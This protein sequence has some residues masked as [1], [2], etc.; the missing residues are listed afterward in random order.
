M[1]EQPQLPVLIAGAGPC[2]LVAALTLKQQ[3]IP[4]IVIERASRSK[5]CANVGSGYD[6]APTALDILSNRL[7]LEKMTEIYSNF[8]GLRIQDMF[9][10]D[11]R[12]FPMTEMAKSVKF[13]NDDN[14]AVEQ[15]FGTVN[16]AD[17]QSMLLEKLFSSPESEEGVLRCG[18]GIQSYT[19]KQGIETNGATNMV[20]V[21]LSDG[22]T[23]DG[24]ALLA[25]DGI[26]S[27]IRKQL[28]QDRK[29]E[30]HFCNIICYWG[31]CYISKGS[32]FERVVLDVTKDGTFGILM[33][34]NGK[35]PGNFMAMK[36][37]NHLIWTLFFKAKEPPGHL[38]GDFTRRG[39]KVLDDSSKGKLLNDIKGR[40]HFLIACL[41]ATNAS[42]I[43][44]AGIFDR[45]DNTVPYTDRKCVAL[46]GDS[47]HP[48]SPYMGQG[49]NMAI[50][51]AYVVASR[52]AK[53]SSLSDVLTNYDTQSRK[54]S[55][56]KVIHRARTIGSISASTNPLTCW[57]MKTFIKF[58]PV[59]WLFADLMSGDQS[60]H[61]LV[62]TLDLEFP[63][64]QG[65]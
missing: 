20:S 18:A 33:T 59:S 36:C 51:D 53:H 37:N 5:L 57:I 43:T 12:E 27:A 52:L 9:G 31:K 6:L 21:T 64:L 58:L 60:N 35:N 2:G 26:H 40:G 62:A 56:R 42:D 44:E 3:S 39:G 14:G 16:R 63:D 48:Q 38:T 13:L 49:C 17:L 34:G 23:L 8:V 19:Q 54:S 55:V 24:R 15:R 46:L 32:Q 29:D 30:L 50:V 1:S 11:I 61:D 47:A 65:Q 25:C 22:S 28:H 41:E 45:L 4:F 7:H 10:K